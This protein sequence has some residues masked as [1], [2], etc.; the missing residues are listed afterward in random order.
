MDADIGSGARGFTIFD[1]RT[2][3]KVVEF[4]S[5][6][7]HLS[8]DGRYLAYRKFTNRRQ[9][10]DPG[11]RV[12]DL[13]QD[14]G[15]VVISAQAAFE[16]V[17]KQVFPVELS[18]GRPDLVSA[19]RGP[20]IGT[21]HAFH[22]H[23]FEQV[24]WDLGGGALYFLAV[25]RT[26]H[27]N[28]VVTTLAPVPMVACTV[29]LLTAASLRGEHFK[30][31]SAV[32]S[33]GISQPSRGTMIVSLS[34]GPAVRGIESDHRIDLVRACADQSPGYVGRLGSNR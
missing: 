30:R 15:Q 27:L 1:L 19:Y 4:Y 8:P 22:G 21:G 13:A 5:I 6:F 20:D 24:V 11:V 12:L 29:P 18:G 26:G 33:S 25:D 23:P 9:R 16:G 2:D 7:P 3:R 28:L 17:G 31:Q 32:P 10:T 34:Y 14:F